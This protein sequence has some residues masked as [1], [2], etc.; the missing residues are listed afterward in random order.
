MGR[1]TWV[2]PMTVVQKFEANESVA[3]DTQCWRVACERE[4]SFTWW[5]TTAIGTPWPHVEAH[6][7]NRCKNIDN[8]WLYDE[9]GDGTPDKMIELGR[10]VECTL[11]SD[12]DYTIPLRF[13]DIK[14]DSGMTIY[15]TN[16]DDID[17]LYHHVGKIQ[18]ASV[19][20]PNRS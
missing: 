6:D 2:K 19:D 12:A 8:Q 20:H 17:W 9:D 1:T 4:N 7:N 16:R 3:A 18:Q 11:Y 14:P 5:E 15:W 10:N 13:E